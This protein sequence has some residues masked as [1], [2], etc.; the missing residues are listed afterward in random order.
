MWE[1]EDLER[2]LKDRLNDLD[3]DV[4]IATYRRTLAPQLA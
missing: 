3:A 1:D 4:E 2:A